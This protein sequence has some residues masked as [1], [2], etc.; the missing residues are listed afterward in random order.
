M[1]FSFNHGATAPSGPGSHSRDT[2]FG[3][4]PPDVQLADCR[5]VYLTTHNIHKETDIHAPGRIQIRNT[6]KCAARPVPK[7]VRPLR[8]AH[9]D[10]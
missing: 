5:D 1:D 8:V 9:D 2:A 4:M 6:S 7:T 10:I 3:M